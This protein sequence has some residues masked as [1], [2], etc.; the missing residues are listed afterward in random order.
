MTKGIVFDIKEFAVHD[1][2]GIRVTVFMKGCPLRCS[3]CHNPEG[4]LREP[5]IMRGSAGERMAG[6]VYTS[7]ELAARLSS[8]AELM[9][10]GEGGVTFSGGEP[11]A[12]ARFVAEVM[13]Q[14]DNLHVV[15]DTSGHADEADFRWVASKTN[16]VYF[17]LKLAD[18]AQHRLH[19][20]VDNARILQN[21]DVLEDLGVPFVVRVPLIPGVTDTVANLSAIARLVSGM[22]GL[23][24]VDLLPYN[25]AAGAKYAACGLPF[26]PTFDVSR[27]LSFDTSCFKA[28]GIDARVL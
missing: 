3:W 25:R 6:Q 8:Q 19:T 17:D 16:L 22:P 21:L 5:Q 28:A 13:D 27:E 26:Q 2:P 11:V 9:Q 12:Q 18:P 1:G 20:G 24:R 7:A 4:L 15:L 14:L 23:Q 10:M